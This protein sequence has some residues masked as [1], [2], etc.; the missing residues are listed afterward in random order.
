[1]FASKSEMRRVA[2]QSP[3]KMLEHIAE[4]EAQLTSLR[5]VASGVRAGLMRIADE[6]DFLKR[7]L[8]VNSY[9]AALQ[10]ELNE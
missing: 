3:A 4:L 5:R 2:H 6:K 10:R 7:V 8:I 1:M 9:G